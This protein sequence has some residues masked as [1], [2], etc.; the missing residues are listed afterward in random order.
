MRHPRLLL[1]LASLVWLAGCGCSDSPGVDPLNQEELAT[2]PAITPPQLRELLD[3]QK[4]KVVVL[5]VWSVRR[6]ASVDA[7]PQLKAL[8][9]GGPDAEP[10]VIAVNIDRVSDVR[11][12]VL[13][14]VKQA[15]PTFL[16]RVLSVGPEALATFIDKNWT[17]ELPALALYDRAGRKVASGHGPA[18]LAGIQARL[19]KLLKKPKR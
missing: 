7:Y 2:L 10:V 12:K 18:A 1:L 3:A 17:G 13:P 15:Q 14:I 4:G 11:D 9:P 6:Q 16:N 19:P 5:A 8:C